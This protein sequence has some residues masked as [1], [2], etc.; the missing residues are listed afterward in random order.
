MSHC[1]AAAALNRESSGETQCVSAT[2]ATPVARSIA[3]AGTQHAQKR[4]LWDLDAAELLHPLLAFFLLFEQLPLAGDVTAVAL[5]G[6]V[7][8]EGADR[9]ASD[10]FA[11]NRRL[12]RN[13]ELVAGDFLFELLAQSPTAAGARRTVNDRAQGVHPFAFDEDVHLDEV[14]G[15]EADH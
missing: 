12:Q 10:H 9:F 1:N 6:D 11:V 3:V 2:G 14:G 4:L 8:A 5:G 7:L 13:L 15:A